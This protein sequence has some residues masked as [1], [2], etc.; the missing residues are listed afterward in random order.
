MLHGTLAAYH[1]GSMGTKSG[2]RTFGFD[3]ALWTWES[4]STACEAIPLVGFLE[5]PTS[6]HLWQ[7]SPELNQLLA[8][9][10][11]SLLPQIAQ[12]LGNFVHRILVT[13]TRC[14]ALRTSATTRV[15][16]SHLLD[17]DGLSMKT[18][19]LMARKARATDQPISRELLLV[20]VCRIALGTCTHEHR[21]K[22]IG[23]DAACAIDVA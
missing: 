18:V 23:N 11:L 10:R 19:F 8:G 20:H 9:V 7:G 14:G 6:S 13:S 2:C 1:P 5:V 16:R 17:L 22:H 21:W 3:V 4:S 15:A 12:L